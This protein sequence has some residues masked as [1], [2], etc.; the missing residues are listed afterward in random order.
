M[1]QSAREL[2]S[3]IAYV[4]ADLEDYLPLYLPLVKGAHYAAW[5]DSGTKWMFPQLV[6]AMTQ[7]KVSD[8]TL[9]FVIQTHSHADHIGCN[10]QLKQQ[11]GCLIA[12]HRHYAHWHTDL[13]R[14]YQE[15]A[16]P[17]PELMP[18]TA[19]LR[20]GVTGWFDSPHAIDVFI[21]EGS[22]FH[23]GGG[24]TLRAFAF[25]GH[26]LND[27]GWFEASTRTLILGDA[28][29]ATEW[30]H[31]HIHLTVPGYRSTIKKIRAALK[32]FRVETV[33]LT[34]FGPM[35]AG[36]ADALAQKARAFL[37]RVDQSLLEVLGTNDVVPLED[38]WTGVAARMNKVR[39]FQALNTVH[40]HVQDFLARGIL[41]E[42]EPR[43]YTLR[44]S[45]RSALPSA[46]KARRPVSA[47]LA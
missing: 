24:V 25:P 11:T 19:E 35:P 30:P 44:R 20:Q 3:V 16:R 7:A 15:W 22:E 39:D 13:E 46:P 10:V 12:G 6:Q 23:L 4:K 29:T 18:H 9:R 27:L 28:I 31:F 43:V 41:K 37:D 21:D 47:S 42:V 36:E 34:H 38:V 1:M 33:F 14:H 2:N 26:M 8:S 5:V 32:D 40:A 17:V 45:K